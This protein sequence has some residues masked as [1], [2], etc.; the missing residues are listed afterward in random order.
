MKSKVE[1]I[2]I[3][4]TSQDIADA[5]RISYNKTT[6]KRSVDSLLTYM[7]RNHHTSPFEMV[8]LRFKVTCPIFVARQ[9]MRHRTASINEMSGRYTECN[10]EAFFEFDAFR[11]QDTVDKQ[12]SSGEIDSYVPGRVVEETQT[13]C[14][15]AYKNLIDNLHVS[16]EQAR[17]VL[18]LSTMTSFYWKIDLHNFLHFLKL[19]MEVTDVEEQTFAECSPY[20]P[21][22]QAETREVVMDMYAALRLGLLQNQDNS[23]LSA[24][25]TWEHEVLHATTLSVGEMDWLVNLMPEPVRKK[26]YTVLTGLGGKGTTYERAIKWKLRQFTLPTRENVNCYTTYVNSKGQYRFVTQVTE[27][28]DGK[29][30]LY[31]IDLNKQLT[32]GK[33]VPEFA[34]Q[35]D[36]REWMKQ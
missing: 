5:A 15:D 16:R 34:T 33:Y 29:V 32:D 23:L 6:S 28:I 25:N 3:D 11:M 19:R 24:L 7:I 31:Y 18:P 30:E 22:V 21:H 35:E 36:F 4:G 10:D 26:V 8:D 12:A 1:L 27:D 20:T 14:Y 17:A 13:R 9:I 2:R